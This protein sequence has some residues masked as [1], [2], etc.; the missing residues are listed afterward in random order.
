MPNKIKVFLFSCEDYKN[1]VFTDFS[2]ITE[3]IKN[4]ADSITEASFSIPEDFEYTIQIAFMTQ[5][6][7][8]NAPEI[9]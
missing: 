4:D 5:Q 3:W 7:I 8:D 2:G 6:E 9:D 1:V